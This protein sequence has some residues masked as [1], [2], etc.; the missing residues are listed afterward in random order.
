MGNLPCFRGLAKKSGKKQHEIVY[1]SL[2]VMNRL[3]WLNSIM[4]QLWPHANKAINKMAIETILPE[5]RAYVP[6]ISFTDFSLGDTPPV[7]GPITSVQT[8]KGPTTE[9]TVLFH[10][11]CDIQLQLGASFGLKTLQ[12]S[13]TLHVSMEQIIDEIPVVG[14]LTFY[15]VDQPRIDFDLTG[16]A[17]LGDMPGLRGMLRR[18][19]DTVIAGILV[20]PNQ[21]VVPLAYPN[22]PVDFSA[23][24]LPAPLY[25]LRLNVVSCADLDAADFGGTSDPYVVVHLAD[26]TFTSS[27]V[28]ASLNPKF[29]H[30]DRFDF[31]VYDP[32]QRVLASVFDYDTF[33]ADDEL[34]CIVPMTVEE[35]LQ[36]SGRP[37]DLFDADAV[38]EEKTEGA[39][40]HGTLT[41]RCRKLRL[42][43]GVRQGELFFLVAKVGVVALPPGMVGSVVVTFELGDTKVTTPYGTAYVGGAVG[44]NAVLTD[45][46][47]ALG[48]KKMPANDIAEVT[49][50]PA[51]AV[52]D[53]LAGKVLD[54]L[55]VEE[56]KVHTAD[57]NSTMY[58]RMPDD[59]F[60]KQELKVTIALYSGEDLGTATCPVGKADESTLE[61]QG[62]KGAVSADIKFSWCGTQGVP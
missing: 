4:A 58:I 10:S 62:P 26:Q 57:I 7:L 39:Q 32:R 19:I 44:V 24:T 11:D 33:S 18:A 2:E 46:I 36:T 56:R 28:T 35:A 16:L 48:A 53:V 8:N 50:L 20:L 38:M 17:N 30:K 1:P 52:Q 31:M 47:A 55:V 45:I 37:I 6:G 59:F 3:D 21:F 43:P 9:V 29:T 22:Q 41:L 51:R 15:F 5:I 61:F 40:K 60:A 14:G 54:P 27:T 13:G 49:G 34:G 25:V 42:V 12:F 23:M